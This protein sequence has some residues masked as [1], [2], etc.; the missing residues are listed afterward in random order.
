MVRVGVGEH[1]PGRR[2]HHQV[3]G[4]QH[5]HLGGRE[6]GWQGGEKKSGE[7]GS[8]GGEGEKENK[9]KMCL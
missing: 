2:L 3:H 6:G 1:P 4:L 8:D 7:R 9:K 5:W